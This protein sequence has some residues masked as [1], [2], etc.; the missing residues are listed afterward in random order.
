[1][2]APDPE[3]AV[4]LLPLIDV[5]IVN[6]GEAAAMGGV[7]DQH[8]TP[9]TL[10]DAL[11]RTGARDVVITLGADGACGWHDGSLFHQPSLKVEVVD[12]TGAGDAFCGAVAARLLAGDALPEAVRFG[13]VAGALSAT[14]PGAQ[15]SIPT[16]SE[17]TRALSSLD[18]VS[19]Q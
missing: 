6:R 19:H 14:K 7:A 15:S 11:R 1:N 4:D 2:A 16:A 12:T 17:I 5:L 10:L 3:I 9:E 13:V 18:N 8:A